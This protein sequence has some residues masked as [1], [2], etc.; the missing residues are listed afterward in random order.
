MVVEHT[1]KGFGVEE[2]LPPA[3]QLVAVGLREP[4][5]DLGRQRA[6][7]LAVFQ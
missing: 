2:T 5:L 4:R 1:V 6:E 3:L 7:T